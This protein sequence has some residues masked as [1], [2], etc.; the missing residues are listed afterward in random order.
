MRLRR[1]IELCASTATAGC[2]VAPPP[3]L[4][5]EPPVTRPVF[6]DQAGQ[7]SPRLGSQV[8]V[9]RADSNPQVTF[10]VPVDDENVNDALQ[11]QFYVNADR[12]CVGG[13]RTRCLPSAFNTYPPANRRQRIIEQTLTFGTL[14]CNRVELWVSSQFTTGDNLRTPAREGDFAF[15]TWYVYVKAAPGTGVAGDAGAEDPA[16]NCAHLVPP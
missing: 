15:T 2:L 7:T 4:P 1:V 5:T 3:S 6:V 13:D 9:T 12:D 16:E 8:N 11:F 14:G 10:R